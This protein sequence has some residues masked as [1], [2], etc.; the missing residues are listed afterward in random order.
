MEELKS[1]DRYVVMVDRTKEDSVKVGDTE[2]FLD[3]RFNEYEHVTQCGTVVQFPASEKFYVDDVKLG[4]T[5]Y[6]HHFV[7]SQE[8]DVSSYFGGEKNH[9]LVEKMNIYARTRGEHTCALQNF[10]FLT[11]IEEKEEDIKTESGIYLKPVERKVWRKGVV[12]YSVNPRLKGLTVCF[13]HNHDYEMTVAGERL[14][15]M[16]EAS[17]LAHLSV[18]GEYEPSAD[19]YIVKDLEPDEKKIMLGGVELIIPGVGATDDGRKTK[20][21]LGLLIKAGEDTSID[22]GTTIYFR[23]GKELKDG[24]EEAG[25]DFFILKEEDIEAILEE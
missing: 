12:R 18:T 16:T 11:P 7:C 19:G 8:N 22:V 15:R 9:Y 21:K 2:L 6:F 20:F 5:I 3:T 14:Y 1:I 13:K 4:D 24:F 17:L 23:K 25:E 10:V